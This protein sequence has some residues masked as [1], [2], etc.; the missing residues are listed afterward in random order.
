VLPSKLSPSMTAMPARKQLEVSI[1]D[2]KGINEKIAKL[3]VS[4]LTC[5][6]NSRLQIPIIL[7]KLQSMFRD[8]SFQNVKKKAKHPLSFCLFEGWFLKI[9]GEVTSGG[10]APGMNAAIRGIVRIAHSKKL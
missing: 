10:D 1:R 4:L 9:I 3:T 5:C 8:R 7:V 6:M 2:Y